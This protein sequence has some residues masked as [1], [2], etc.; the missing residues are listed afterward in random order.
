MSTAPTIPPDL[1]WPDQL[2]DLLQLE[3]RRGRSGGTAPAPDPELAFVNRRQRDRQRDRLRAHNALQHVAAVHDP[4]VL[5]AAARMLA[6]TCPFSGLLLDELEQ[7]VLRAAAAAVHAK[8]RPRV[9][10]QPDRKET[11]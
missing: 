3:H 2:R 8:R 1:C 4:Q 7:H 11:P 6:C 9:P 5:V 10:W